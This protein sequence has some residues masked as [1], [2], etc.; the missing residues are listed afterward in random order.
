MADPVFAP[1]APSPI[2]ADLSYDVADVTATYIVRVASWPTDEKTV[3]RSLKSVTGLSGDV[4][5]FSR[6]SVT[7]LFAL[8]P[9]TWLI[10]TEESDIAN[11]LLALPEDQAAT[12]DVSGGHVFF[13]VSGDHA[14][15]KLNKGAILDFS[16]SA[17][18]VGTLKQTAIHHMP[19]V[20]ARTSDDAFV[21]STLRSF[22]DELQSWLKRR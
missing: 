2:P 3:A 4:G 5:T 7:T 15:F 18:P 9:A 11:A 17:F 6:K 14:H 22:G 10:T 19:T 13:D 1:T 21:V 8:S 12:T 20:I 16:V